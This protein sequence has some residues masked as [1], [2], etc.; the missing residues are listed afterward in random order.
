[1]GISVGDT[2]S[3]GSSTEII[4]IIGTNSY[5]VEATLDSSQIPSVK[6]GQSATVEVDGVN[7]TIDG[8]VSQVGPVQSSDG[9]Y[10]YPVVVG[11][12][13]V[14]RP[15]MFTGSTANVD[16]HD[17]IGVQRGRRAHLCRADARARAPTCSRLDK[18]ELTRKVIKVGMV[19]DDLHAGRS[20]G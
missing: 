11:A 12:A 10:S 9:G 8:T 2:V 13:R 18:G 6:V 7:G 3:A 5:E 14:R 19:G 4:T 15:R 20:R 17:G 1:M 16:H